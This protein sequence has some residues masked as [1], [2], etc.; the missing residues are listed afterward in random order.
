MTMRLWAG[1]DVGVE[2]TAVCVIDDSGQAV[3]EG[4]CATELKSL[5]RELSCL[6]RRRFARVCLEAGPGMNLARGLRSL[7]YRVD[8]FE[9]RQL[10]K[11]LRLRRNKTDAGDASGIAEAGRLGASTISRVHLKSLECQFLQSRLVIRRHLIRQRVAAA[12][13][14]GRQLEVY[15]GRVR[16][17]PG[18]LRS[19][20]DAEIRKLFGKAPNA[21]TSELRHLADHCE[22]LLAYQ[23]SVD[24]ELGRWAAANDV[25]R[26][27]M[28]ITG[29]GP[30]CAL[31]FYSAID[32]PH[33]FRRSSDVGSYFG[34][35]PATR[36]S[37]LS[38]R[39]G[40][41]SKMGNKAV[42]SLLVQASMSF[43]RWS[44]PHSKL[45]SWAG[46]VEQRRGPAKARIALARKLA[47]VMVAMWKSGAAYRPEGPVFHESVPAGGDGR[48][49]TRQETMP[50]ECV[51]GNEGNP[52][53]SLSEAAALAARAP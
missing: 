14:L 2:T 53:V 21:L 35:T 5:H 44:D 3:H 48:V 37:G 12:N 13:L 26:R 15:G 17:P 38:L 18:K 28:D 46:R 32:D 36:Q 11:F 9:A 10:S 27:F 4:R 6:R 47:T 25:C 41:I 33:R 52:A 7:G 20:V 22:Q 16:S 1:I 24:R 8:L 34:L 39:M 42:R 51:S 40:K 29:V 31:A 23:R 19:A 50:R 43:M 45:R 30:I 49:G